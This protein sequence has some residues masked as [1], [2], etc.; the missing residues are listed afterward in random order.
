MV[1]MTQKVELTTRYVRFFLRPADWKGRMGAT[2]DALHRL[3]AIEN[4]L[5]S[6]RGRIEAKKRQAK[7]RGRRVATLEKQVAE[8]RHQITKDQA[9]ADRFELERQTHEAHINKLRE[10]L[11][12]AKT[13][14]E[15]AAVL[16][17]LNTDKSDA[18]K[19]ED[20]VLSALSKVDELKKQVTELEAT[21]QKEE[22]QAT[23]LKKASDAIE[24]ELDH[25]IRDLENQR[26]EATQNIPPQTLATFERA[27]VKHDGEA[28]AMIERTHPKRAE[29][30][31]TGCHM[32]VTL[33][34]ISALQSRDDIWQCQNCSR[35]LYLDAP[36]SVTI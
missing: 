3:Q 24:Q 36:A 7:A 21:K 34:T 6:A 12:Q 32:S 28:M 14:K 1:G 26:T 25:Q 13:N 23:E 20:Q 22:Q 10:A 16:T 4:Q 8:T 30:V 15:Y 9:D 29:Y 2:L 35:I 18:M 27:C 17:Q 31:C 33:E 11:N 19:L 5:R